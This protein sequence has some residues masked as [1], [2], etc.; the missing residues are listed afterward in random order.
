MKYYYCLASIELGMAACGLE[1]GASSHLE[2]SKSNE[3]ISMVN[4]PFDTGNT[5][6]FDFKSNDSWT[7]DSLVHIFPSEMTN[8]NV[9]IANGTSRLM[10]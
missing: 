9:Y 1:Q 7:N 2:L 8:V 10:A 5:C 3:T 4:I 6:Y